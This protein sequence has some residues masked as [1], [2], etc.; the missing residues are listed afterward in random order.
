MYVTIRRETLFQFHR[1]NDSNANVFFG[2]SIF[3]VQTN[4]IKKLSPRPIYFP[5][6]SGLMSHNFVHH[7]TLIPSHRH[8]HHTWKILYIMITFFALKKKGL[9]E[10]WE[11]ERKWRIEYTWWAEPWTCRSINQ[12]HPGHVGPRRGLFVRPSED[13]YYPSP[14]TSYLCV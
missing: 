11:V 8:H 12:H 4:K 2:F 9:Y 14:W 6:P 7:I 1:N 5:S 13:F 10:L 3:R